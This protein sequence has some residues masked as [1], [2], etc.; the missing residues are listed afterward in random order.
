MSHALG[1]DL[2]IAVRDIPPQQIANVTTT[3][4]SSRNPKPSPAVKPLNKTACPPSPWSKL[5]G[6]PL[7]RSANDGDV[8]LWQVRL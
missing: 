7:D 2:D 3:V 5:R 8:P 4:A 6:L 1:A